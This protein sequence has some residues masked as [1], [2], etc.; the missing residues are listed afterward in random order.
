LGDDLEKN[1]ITVLA[2]IHEDAEIARHYSRGD[3]ILETLPNYIDTYLSLA[4]NLEKLLGPISNS[5]V[6]RA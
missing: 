2:V 1:H 5:H 6:R 3:I 4:T